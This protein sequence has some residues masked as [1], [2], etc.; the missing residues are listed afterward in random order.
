[1]SD[2]P[3]LC[4]LTQYYLPEMGAPQVRLSE[5]ADRLAARG[6]SVEVLTAHPNY[7]R[8]QVYPGYPRWRTVVENIGQAR[9]VR[10]PI[11]PSNRGMAGRL[12]TYLSFMIATVLLGRRRCRQPDVLLVESPPLFV[13]VSA[14][15]LARRWKCPYVFNVSDLWPASAVH[16]GMIE[17]GAITKVARILEHGT[18][19]GARLITGQ[20][21]EIIAAVDEVKGAAPTLLV[22]NGVEPAR[23]GSEHADAEAAATLG[24]AEGVV[25]FTYAGLLGHAQGLDQ[26]LDAARLLPPD[27]P[28]QFRLIGTGPMRDHLAAR[29]ADECIDRVRIVGEVPRERVPALLAVSDVAL[30]TLGMALPGAVPSKIY[31]AMA[32]SLPILLVA[33]GE[34]KERVE[35]AAAGMV[36]QPGDVD[37]LVEVMISLSDDPELR[38]TLGASGR[39]A[40]ETT[41]SRDRIVGDLDVTLRSVL[42]GGET[43][44]ETSSELTRMRTVY[45]GYEG[46]RGSD[47]EDDNPANAAA[48]QLVERRLAAA[49]EPWTRAAGPVRVLDVG[50]G[51][52]G[53]GELARNLPVEISTEVG[54]DL[55]EER[56]RSVPS[57][58]RNT[59]AVAADARRLPFADDSFDLIVQSTMLSSVLDD[60]I[61]HHIAQDID[62]VLAPG[63]A[64]AWYDLRV[65]NPQNKSVRGYSL[66]SIKSLF[67]GYDATV[68]ST[69]VV[70]PLARRLGAATPRLYSWL[71]RVP[72]LRTHLV[73]LLV[74]PPRP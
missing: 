19:R 24:L 32:S 57:G 59:P 1:M 72:L 2:H 63:G 67:P 64:I 20:S 65:R 48:R 14:R 60:T 50:C 23:F 13:A 45:A 28:A 5:L 29:I 9:V 70:P 37:A 74:K 68:R 53:G 44:V 7:P 21:S 6:W 71:D 40:A 49:A 46:T 26:I 47:W 51:V 22:T 52:G 36:V 55:L 25:C 58:Q 73:G 15:W 69:T 8:G 10:V 18:Y 16:M 4:V 11:V 27:C 54:V 56:L 12:L 38:H 43:G 39:S 34:P 62:R 17:E 3:R 66:S 61:A 30:I 42:V 31:E 35:A 33:S 41:Y